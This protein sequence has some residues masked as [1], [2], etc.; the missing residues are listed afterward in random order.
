MGAMVIHASA[1]AM[2]FSRSFA[3]RRH[4]PSQAKARS[5]TQRRGSTSKPLAAS[6]RLTISSVRSPILSSALRSFGP[7]QPPSAKTCRSRGNAWRMDPS[8]AGAPSRSWMS[9]ARATSPTIRP[10]VSGTLW[11]L[12]PLTFLPASKPLTP[13]PSVV[14]A[15]WQSITPAEG[16]A[17]RPSRSRAA[18]TRYWLTA[19]GRPLSRHS[20]KW[21]CTVAGGG[22]SFGRQAHWQP[23][24]AMWR[25]AFITSRKSVVRGRPMRRGEGMEGPISAR[26]RFVGSLA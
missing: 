5:T 10:S 23:V 19:F 25:I 15:L 8:T 4:R 2:V 14:L 1:L 12:R 18:L 20:W 21:R 6:E 17:S 22:T 7:A 24:D 13:P 3:R 11:R 16:V 9:A 26:S